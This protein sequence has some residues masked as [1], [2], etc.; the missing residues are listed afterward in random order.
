[1]QLHDLIMRGGGKAKG[2][3]EQLARKAPEIPGE[4]EPIED[5]LIALRRVRPP[6]RGEAIFVP[7]MRQFA[8]PLNRDR[9]AGLAPGEPARDVLSRPEEIHGA[10]SE[11]NVIPPAGR[12]DQ[13]VKE[14]AFVIGSLIA[15][16]NPQRFTTVRARRL[17]PPVLVQGG[18]DAECIPGTIPVPPPSGRLNTVGGG[19]TGE[20]VRHPDVAGRGVENER[21]LGVKPFPAGHDLDPAAA[22]NG[23]NLGR[24]W[25][26][27]ELDEAR[28]GQIAQREVVFIHPAFQLPRHSPQDLLCAV[29]H[30]CEARFAAPA[31]LGGAGRLLRVVSGS[32]IRPLYRQ[33][34]GF[35]DGILTSAG[36]R[37]ARPVSLFEGAGW[38]RPGIGA[39]GSTC[40][41][42]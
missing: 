5:R 42:C 29:A 40:G 15:H 18:A 2:G 23:G 26:A 39:R 21:V 35:A 1:M 34:I 14:Q 12:G 28:I 4:P 32:D 19:D 24:R 13:A 20:R 9:L 38:G 10:S 31:A 41:F 36:L 11:D 33:N 6:V 7:G 17:D 16:R 30:A 8:Q 37:C 25:R 27:A 3:H 22:T